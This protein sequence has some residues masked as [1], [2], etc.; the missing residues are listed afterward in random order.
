MDKETFLYNVAGWKNRPIFETENF[1][2]QERMKAYNIAHSFYRRKVLRM[3]LGKELGFLA[4]KLTGN[5]KVELA[6]K[7]IVLR[8]GP[9]RF[10][11]NKIKKD[12]ATLPSRLVIE[13]MTQNT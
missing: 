6:L 13:P 4:W 3:K 1:T 8:P 7:K 11:F 2:E 9:G 12:P 5:E 10:L